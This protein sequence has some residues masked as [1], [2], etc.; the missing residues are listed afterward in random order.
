MN[1]ASLTPYTPR[2]L[3]CTYRITDLA[4]SVRAETII[5][6]L[7]RTTSSNN[8]KSVDRQALSW[9]RL[10]LIVAVQSLPLS[11]ARS[12][13]CGQDST[14]LG[15][16]LCVGIFYHGMGSPG[17]FDTHYMSLLVSSIS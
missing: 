1:L 8:N 5:M 17:A 9:S 4:V 10:T 2:H 6:M 3:D 12:R 16:V 15:I 7:T 14:S 11:V 13:D